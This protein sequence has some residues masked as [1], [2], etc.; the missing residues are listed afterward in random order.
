VDLLAL[1][2]GMA[3]RVR[4]LDP[5]GAAVPKAA[6]TL[7]CAPARA[8]KA[9]T[10]AGGEV[11]FR[12]TEAPSCAIRVEARGFEPLVETAV[13]PDATGLL[14]VRLALARR[15]EK[16]TVG[17]DTRE[18]LARER[19]FSQV[20]T[21]EEIASLPDDPEEMENELRRRAGPGAVL[22]V[23]GFSGGRLPPKSQIRQI[24]IQTSRFAAEYHEGGHPGIDIVT[25][26]GLGS[27][28]TAVG[29]GLRDG[30]WA[31]RPPLAS[32]GA[33][34]SAHRLSLTLD[35]PLRKERTSL[36]LQ[37]Q[38][39]D[40]SDVSAVTALFPGAPATVSL[41]QHKLD[42]QG[43]VEHAWGKTQTARAEVQHDTFDRD[44]VGAGGLALPERGYADDRAEDLIRLSN[45]GVTFGS[46]ATDTRLQLRREGVTWTPETRGP[47]IDVLGAFSSG[48]A[49]LAGTRRTW[50]LEL[51]QDFSRAL[52]RHA[53][54]AGL[55]YEGAFL[56][57][58]ERRNAEGTFTFASAD[59]WHA[60]RPLL[61]TQRT[62]DPRVSVD[63]HRIG[64]YA[65]D[66]W[67]PTDAVALNGGV[68]YEAQTFASGGASFAPRLGLTWALRPTLTVR[69]GAGRF[70]D[71]LEA[72]PVAQVRS[73]DGTHTQDVSIDTPGWPDP[74][75][76]G[77]AAE[78]T[79]R[80]WALATD[81]VLP[82]TTRLSLGVER[83]LGPVRLNTEYAYERG[84][85]VLRARNQARD[86]GRLFEVR[87]EGR[88]RAHT[89]RTDA[90]LGAP[91]RRAGGM[92]GYMF[93]S[94]RNDTDGPLSL[95]ADDTNLA[96]EWGPAADDARHRLFGFGH[97]RVLGRLR[98]SGQVFAQSGLPWDA[99]TGRDGNGDTVAN[100]RP[101]GVTRNAQRGDWT[102]D[103]GLRLAWDFGFGG[104]RT[105][106]PRG[107][108]MI[109]V[110]LGGDDGPPDVGGGP[111]EQRYG[112][113]VYALASNVLNHLNPTRY[114]NVVGSPLFGQPVEAVPGRRLEIGAR[115]RF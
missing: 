47:A 75:A 26:P 11:A 48:G 108:Q 57:S 32:A 89:L 73:G 20:L 84:S 58:D 15:E 35:G 40:T 113:Q 8:Q 82:R 30:A 98:A 71:W 97:W 91:G 1:L 90:M 14:A 2:I 38:S 92:I 49:T 111:D 16:V 74:R 3:W 55:L 64:L 59:D 110:R 70:F 77:A 21:P 100:D 87:A 114:G 105:S 76:T 18:S 78:A 107:P 54:R 34:Q 65:Q 37:L 33:A 93:R 79:P 19:S 85:S 72:D 7:E 60:G 69:A 31:S 56:R 23:N 27:W 67:R 80:R 4:V 50:S 39:R 45:Q 94:S 36:S 62:G 42:L 66:D 99:I 96:A 52:G 81:L 25:R 17:E 44:G 41:P 6:V 24:R 9:V 106:G 95:P 83:S 68:R 5:S 13:A 86:G 109:A 29:G 102:V 28:R 51:G 104:P 112:I 53:L 63:L 101:A 43:R 103:A 46:W 61:F 115:F 88:A 22:R 10:G 12:V